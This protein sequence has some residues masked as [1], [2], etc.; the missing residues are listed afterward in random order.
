MNQEEKEMS[1]E[2]IQAYAEAYTSLVGLE[3]EFDTTPRYT[4]KDMAALIQ[5]SEHTVRFYDK[6][7]IFPFVVRDRNNIRL[8]SK[9]DAFFGRAIK[10]LR[11]VELSIEDCR[12]FVLLTLQGDATVSER[13]QIMREQ[14]E[15]LERKIEELKRELRDIRY[16]RM[17]FKEVEAEINQERQEGNFQERGRST[18]KS[19]RIYIQEKMWED[20]LIDH[21]Q[22]EIEPG[23]RHSK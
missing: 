3:N 19:S 20:G 17:F 2:K 1:W 5:I 23:E 13:A 11:N 15:K 4:V 18:L 16:K 9:A 7:H 6:E 10:C 21:I 22:I 8:F 12:T 14:E